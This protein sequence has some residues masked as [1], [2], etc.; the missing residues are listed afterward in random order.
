MVCVYH[1]NGAFGC[2]VYLHRGKVIGGRNILEE[3]K[4]GFLSL[5][6]VLV[7][8]LLEVD[9]CLGDGEYERGVIASGRDGC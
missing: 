9:G 8:Q 5:L 2:L 6:G 4:S 7:S 3:V 1:V